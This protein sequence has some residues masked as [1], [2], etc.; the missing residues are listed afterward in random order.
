MIRTL[1]KA[2]ILA[3]DLVSINLSL[4]FVYWVRYASGWIEPAQPGLEF[5][6]FSPALTVAWI[7]LFYLSGLNRDWSASSRFTQLT[8]ITQVVFGGL[9]VFFVAVSFDQIHQAWVQRTLDLL[10]TQ[11]KILTM[12]YYGASLVVLAMG[13]RELARLLRTGIYRAGWGREPVLII[14]ANEEGKRIMDILCQAPELGEQAA[15]FVDDDGNKKGSAY[16]GLPVLG[17]YSDLPRLIREKRIKSVI[18]SHVSSSHNEILKIV[19]Y[20]S[21]DP[22]AV[23][24]LPDLYDVVSGHFKTQKI[25]GVPFLELLS[26]H[27]PGWQWQMKRGI[28]ILSAFIALTVFA[29]LLGLVALLV[30]LSSA[31]PIFFSQE[32]VGQY[33]K[34]FRMYKFRSMVMDAE[35][36]TGPMWA[37]K[38]DPRIFPW[39]RFMRRSRLDE[40]P[41]FY[42]ILKGDMSLVGPRPERRYFVEQ[43][44]KEIPVY[45]RR[46]KM[47]PGI[48]GWAQVKHKYDTSIEDTR[49]K[50]MLDLYYF[51]NMSILLDI[52]IMLLTIWVVLTGKGAR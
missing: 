39:G 1:E 6:L 23:K 48:T 3:A 50:V 32:R 47:K 27:L 29:P 13:G 25:H 38:D 26:Q 49:T 17:T 44:Q 46:L 19:G 51:E 2:F 10:V 21:F 28:D 8:I 15:G 30:R 36:L 11:T 24:L 45:A 43:L 14:G 5:N 4:V 35:R 40:L 18:L 37:E 33:G 7:G 34:E 42:N 41:Q 52:K 20:C 12:V 9:T 31:G 16:Q 22:V